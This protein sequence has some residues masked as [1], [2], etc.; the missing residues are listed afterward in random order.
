MT[1]VICETWNVHYGKMSCH[2]HVPSHASRELLIVHGSLS[3]CDPGNI[4]NTI[5]VQRM[6]LL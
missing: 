5:E 4:F 1:C 3:S 2:R 6:T